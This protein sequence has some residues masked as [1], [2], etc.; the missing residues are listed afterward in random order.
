MRTKF[1]T[2]VLI[3]LICFLAILYFFLDGWIESGLETAGEAIVGARVEIDD[4]RLT[5]IP[6]GITFQRLQVADPR[7]P[8]T[9]TVE[10][11]RVAF[12]LDFGQLLR[13]KYI[14]E[15]MEVNDL[16]LGSE[17]ETDGSLR[18]EPGEPA[19]QAGEA[20]TGGPAPALAAE[21]D[22]IS[23]EKQAETPMFD[24]SRLRSL[25]NVDSLLNAGNLATLRHVDSLNRQIREAEAEWNAALADIDR[26][27]DRIA[28]I[29]QR[30]KAIKIDELKSLPAI[31]EAIKN[32]DAVRKDVGELTATLQTRREAVTTSIDRLNR[33]VR[34][35]DDLVSSDFE[36]LL[37]AAR[38]PDV[39]MR[40][41]AELLL[42]PGLFDQAG[43]Y[44]SYVD[45]ARTNIKNSSP[46]PA[47][48]SPPRLQGQ[49]I[50]F[51]IE[52]AFPKFW[53][54]K[55]HVSG[56]TDRDRNP[57]YFYAA[58]EILNISSNQ[59]ITGLPLTVD[60]S[61]EQG[62]GT[63]ASINASIDRRQ[64]DPLDTYAARITGLP[65]ASMSL[66]R[67]NFVPSRITGAKGDFSVQAT[68]PGS[69]FDADARI[70]LGNL[71]L[72]FERESRNT[73]ERLVREVL[74][75]LSAINIRLRLWKAGQ[76]LQVA[77][78]TDMDNQLAAQVRRVIG[79]EVARVRNELRSKLERKIADK[80]R[81]VER[82]FQEKK[83]GVTQRLRGYETRV[84]EVTGL[85]DSKKAELDQK[86]A[87]E[88]KKQED[89]LKK[90]GQDVLK[91]IF[92]K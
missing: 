30:V 1:I 56:G 52:T 27:R 90:K 51:P 5:L 72:E 47:K 29:E 26:S 89:A 91:G 86:L 53:I 62:R 14:I 16:I 55:I 76:G 80:R 3:P 25:V 11:G 2:V 23:S 88:K 21:M 10:T 43:E 63:T 35:I 34:D 57:N 7:E 73:V 9:N 42:G 44:L 32:A 12:A 48:A 69:G 38:L 6:I 58:G 74:V 84:K 20:T 39:S 28:E 24:V 75:S 36:D 49:D 8:M 83:D 77:L 64:D 87:E 81:D 66:G 70:V 85:A 4:L 50:H 15:T 54:K 67:S 41:L 31:T 78:E 60:L 19:A 46:T 13:G 22:S 71:K 33:S 61:A 92:K 79:E 45:F 65:I 17:R 59:R 82:L 18:K 40:G 68:V 37:K